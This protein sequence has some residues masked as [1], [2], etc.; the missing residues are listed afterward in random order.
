[1]VNL[2]SVDGGDFGW[3]FNMMVACMVYL[4]TI[5]ADEGSCR[6]NKCKKG[7]EC[8]KSHVDLGN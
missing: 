8:D 1:V 4:L 7:Y 6:L 5:V 2:S 3:K